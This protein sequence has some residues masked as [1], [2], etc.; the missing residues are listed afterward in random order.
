MQKCQI[1]WDSYKLDYNNQWISNPVSSSNYEG[2]DEAF[3]WNAFHFGLNKYLL[4]EQNLYKSFCFQW[5]V[6][7]KELSLEYSHPFVLLSVHLPDMLFSV[8]SFLRV[9]IFVFAENITAIITLVLSR[10][11]TSTQTYIH[12]TSYMGRKVR[13][14]RDVGSWVYLCKDLPSK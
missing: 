2:S 8:R 4:G 5:L 1:F 11:H 6:L 14:V 3:S 10:A 12:S 9:L 13:E 7:Y